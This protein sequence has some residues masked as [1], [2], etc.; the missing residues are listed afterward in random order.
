MNFKPLHNYVLVKANK[1][2][3]EVTKSGI[4]LPVVER[5][6]SSENFT[7]GEVVAVGLGKFVNEDRTNVPEVKVG[8]KVLFALYVGN[9]IKIDGESF[10]M[11]N[12][13]DICAVVE[14]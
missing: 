3:E 2:K 14:E 1:E 9:E 11:M 8:D 4:I 6:K 5:D 7:S 10:L 13:N 12:S